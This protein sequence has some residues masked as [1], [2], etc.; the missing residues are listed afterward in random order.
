MTWTHLY[1]VLLA[2]D[3]VPSR[4]GKNNSN[5]QRNRNAKKKT[6]KQKTAVMKLDIDACCQL[7]YVYAVHTYTHI[8]LYAN[9]KAG[10]RNCIKILSSITYKSGLILTCSIWEGRAVSV[11]SRKLGGKKQ[12]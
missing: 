12:Y 4:E 10:S 2:L 8:H 9:C 11:Y 6:P 7:E 1:F 3:L 5:R